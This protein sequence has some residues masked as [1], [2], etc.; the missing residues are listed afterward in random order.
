MNEVGTLC[1]V[2]DP[3]RQLRIQEPAPETQGWIKI[4][5]V[6]DEPMEKEVKK[7]EGR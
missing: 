7:E 1:S 5:E 3:K 4:A 6:K 2:Q